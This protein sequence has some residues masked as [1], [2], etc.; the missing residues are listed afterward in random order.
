MYY[1]ENFGCETE[2]SF[3]FTNEHIKAHMMP[4]LLFLST[5]APDTQT[6]VADSIPSSNPHRKQGADPKILPRLGRPHDI[7]F[8]SYEGEN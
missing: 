1:L 7:R 4:F 2:M 5:S 3:H 8:V 6:Q